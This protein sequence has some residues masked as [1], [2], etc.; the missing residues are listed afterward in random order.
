MGKQRPRKVQCL[1]TE[2]RGGLLQS[3]KP[4][5]WNADTPTFG[6]AHYYYYYDYYYSALHLKTLP[7]LLLSV[8][9][10]LSVT[11]PSVTL[12]TALDSHVLLN[13]L[14]PASPSCL[15]TQSSCLKFYHISISEIL[16]LWSWQ[17]QSHIIN[18][19]PENIAQEIVSASPLLCFCHLF[20]V[21]ICFM[22]QT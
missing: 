8:D 10:T 3:C 12:L 21:S 11:Q 16:C 19:S 5:N 14:E 2:L 20:S 17:R 6:A 13:T 7:P 9:S 1:I 15:H 22:L 4:N 18:I